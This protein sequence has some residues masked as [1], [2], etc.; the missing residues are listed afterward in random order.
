MKKSYL[1]GVLYGATCLLCVTSKL[2]AATLNYHEPSDGYIS[3]IAG[4]IPAI[5]TSLGT[6]DVGLNTVGG[7]VRFGT[8]GFVDK[9][10]FTVALPDNL[11]IDSVTLSLG[12]GDVSGVEQAGEITIGNIVAPFFA[13][14]GVQDYPILGAPSSLD[15]IVDGFSFSQPF[16]GSDWWAGAT[17]EWDI[18]VSAIPIP[19]AVWFFCSGLLGLIAISRRRK[20]G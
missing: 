14:S 20:A 12:T 5:A 9:D 2:D 7:K 19:S 10:W 8:D 13:V 11:K 3:G 15:F 1:L 17:Y 6:L 16:P 4:D 18:S